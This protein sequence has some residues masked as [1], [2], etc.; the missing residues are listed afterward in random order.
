MTAFPWPPTRDLLFVERI[1]PSIRKRIARW[2]ILGRILP[3]R[4]LARL[5]GLHRGG[6]DRD[7]AVLLFTSGSSGEPKGVPLTHRNVLANVCHNARV[8]VTEG[9]WFVERF[10]FVQLS[11]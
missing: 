2:A 11:R 6:R 10:G 1:L 5:L 8:R 4:I 3:T 9:T 7:E